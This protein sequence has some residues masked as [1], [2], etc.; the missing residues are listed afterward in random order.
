MHLILNLAVSDIL[1]LIASPVW[2]YYLTVDW[3]FGQAALCKFLFFLAFTSTWCGLLTVTLMSVQRYLVVLHRDWWAKLGR[4]G[5]KALL[6]CLWTLACILSIS[7]T[8]KGH[9]AK[10]GQTHTCQRI[11]GLD[12]EALAILLCET[13][14][15]FVLPLSI[16]SSSY[17]CLHRKVSQT[18]FFSKQRLTKVVFIIV[19]TFVIFWM[20]YHVNNLLNILAIIL[21]PAYPLVSGKLK[22]FSVLFRRMTYCFTF[23][24]S[25][26]NP[27]LYACTFTFSKQESAETKK[28]DLHNFH[29]L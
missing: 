17:Y 8:A 29:S 9:I 5:E 28:R 26:V 4:K 23:L 2:I 22:N 14:L 19:L 20:P 18:A 1:C 11:S 13:L 3:T 16:I 24:N 21:K 10:E 7:A 27:F 15:G 12:Q 6:F 25:C